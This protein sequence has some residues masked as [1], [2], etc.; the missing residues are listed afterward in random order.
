MLSE[1]R[2]DRLRTDEAKN[3][4]RARVNA[5]QGPLAPQTFRE[6]LE[7]HRLSAPFLQSP[8]TTD[9]A[10]IEQILRETSRRGLI[11]D[12]SM[13]LRQATHSG[14]LLPDVFELAPPFAAALP[15]VL[16]SLSAESEINKLRVNAIRRPR[17]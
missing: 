14:Q 13:L 15:D 8:E 9:N 16:D 6:A 7:H 3:V 4:I 17:S 12:L 11:T 1:F 2:L 5:A 10:A